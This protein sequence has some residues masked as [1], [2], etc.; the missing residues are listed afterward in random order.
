[1]E[2]GSGWDEGYLIYLD[3]GDNHSRYCLEMQDMQCVPNLNHNQNNEV[4]LTATFRQCLTTQSRKIE[5]EKL[6]EAAK[7]DPE[8]L[9]SSDVLSKVG[10]WA[11]A[12]RAGQYQTKYLIKSSGG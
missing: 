1:M 3:R 8:S 6:D 4:N 11:W 2:S 12:G 7:L 5:T 10:T 9:N